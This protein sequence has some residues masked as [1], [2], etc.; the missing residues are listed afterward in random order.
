MIVLHWLTDYCKEEN[1]SVWVAIVNGCFAICQT[2]LWF[3]LRRAK[4]DIN[5]VA[6]IAGTKRA[7]GEFEEKQTKKP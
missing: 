4:K 1:T 7:I 2:Y 3:S 6:F 5:N